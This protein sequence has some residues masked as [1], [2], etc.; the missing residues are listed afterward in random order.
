MVRRSHLRLIRYHGKLLRT[1]VNTRGGAR[2]CLP[3][4]LRVTV[5]DDS[6]HPMARR[7]HALGLQN[8][9]PILVFHSHA[10]Q[11]RLNAGA[12]LP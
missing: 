7:L 10:L 11:L 1:L 4:S 8:V 2:T 6:K 3:G 9:K 5:S 12:V